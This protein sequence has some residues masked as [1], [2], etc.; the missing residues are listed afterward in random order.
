[1]AKTIRE[2][3]D[4]LGVSKT[5]V[6]KKI[7]NLGLSDSLQTIGNRILVD[8]RQESLIKSA[9][10]KTETE[11]RKQK[12]VCE[13]Q[14]LSDL[15]STLQQQLAAKDKQIES[16][17]EQLTK[18]TAA[19]EHT[20]T[21]LQAAQALHAGTIQQQLTSGA[22]PQQ[23]APAAPQQPVTVNADEQPAQD[24]AAAEKDLKP[25][26]YRK[27]IRKLE[28]DLALTQ[29]EL[30]GAREASE[31]YRKE[32]GQLKIEIGQYESRAKAA[33]AKVAEAEEAVQRAEQAEAKATEAA[34]AAQRAEMAEKRVKDL[35]KELEAVQSRLEAL[36]EV[37][38]FDR[39]F[40]WGSI[41]DDAN[42]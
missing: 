30:K 3:A 40:R 20:T 8:E 37:G 31:H 42:R 5:A 21:S 2:I 6:R 14:L 10:E 39:I 23:E 13:N 4:E 11:N 15:V 7:E 24:E 32:N 17:Q 28:D 12:P 16:Q 9:F 36:T 35:E 38:A 27:K 41:L 22:V 18:L 1:M 33:E 29:K 34:G 25:A 26:T 19:L